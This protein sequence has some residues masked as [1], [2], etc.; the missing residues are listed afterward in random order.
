MRK[1]FKNSL[2]FRLEHIAIKQTT[3]Q[4]RIVKR[5]TIS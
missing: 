5:Y 2:K 4:G 1:V 3:N